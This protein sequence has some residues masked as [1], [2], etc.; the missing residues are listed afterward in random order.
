MEA[1][2][3]GSSSPA[4]F[5]KGS[6]AFAPFVPSQQAGAPASRPHP[7]LPAQVTGHSSGASPQGR[8]AETRTGTTGR[9]R[10]SLATTPG[11]LPCLPPRFQVAKCLRLEGP[12][13]KPQYLPPLGLHDWGR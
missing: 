12:V 2:G 3:P 10:D 11:F 6:Q 5:C 8:E 1:S 13:V 7:A 4:S 9:G